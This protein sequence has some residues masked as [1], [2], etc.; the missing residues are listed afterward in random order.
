MCAVE[1]WGQGGKSYD[2]AS[3]DAGHA[4]E[5]FRTPSHASASPGLVLVPS[6]SS[7]PCSGEVDAM[8]TMLTRDIWDPSRVVQSMPGTH[9]KYLS[10]A[11]SR[12]RRRTIHVVNVGTIVHLATA[13]KNG[14]GRFTRERLCEHDDTLLQ[15]H[16]RRRDG[17][18]HASSADVDS[19][20]R[21]S[22]IAKR[23]ALFQHLLFVCLFVC[24]PPHR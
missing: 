2:A 10:M 1:N 13:P 24:K 18:R 14:A 22:G 23:I 21:T 4:R 9:C 15:G 8:R 20:S 12:N 5:T 3:C 6:P 19:C 17:F 11:A 16:A 7:W